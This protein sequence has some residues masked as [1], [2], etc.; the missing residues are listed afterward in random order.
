MG[1]MTSPA[2]EIVAGRYKNGSKIRAHIHKKRQLRLI[3]LENRAS[4]IISQDVLRW[5]AKHNY[6]LLKFRASR[7]HI[8]TIKSPKT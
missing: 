1:D 4:H 8:R 3:A 6:F 5:V 7:Y 2:N